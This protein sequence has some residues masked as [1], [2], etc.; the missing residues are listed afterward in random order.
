MGADDEQYQEPGRG[1]SSEG[2]DLRIESLPTVEE[3]INNIQEAE[4]DKLSAFSISQEEIDLILCRGSGVS[5][6]K[7]RIF[8]QY[9][10]KQSKQ[11]NIKF[12][13]ETGYPIIKTT[14]GYYMGNRTFSK[15]ERD[16]QQKMLKKEQRLIESGQHFLFLFKSEM[17]ND[18]YK[19]ILNEKINEK[20]STQ[21]IYLKKCIY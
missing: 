12:L 7:F 14:R 8:E 11:D 6:G 19:N 10:K 1:N 2:T 20:T 21:L 16:Y 3:Q 17:F 15:Q 5:K 13:K 18:H 9:Q 4:S